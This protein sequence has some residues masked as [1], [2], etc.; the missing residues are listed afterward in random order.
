MVL[1]YFVGFGNGRVSI[2][3]IYCGFFFFLLFSLHLLHPL[4]NFLAINRF[5]AGGAVFPEPD[6]VFAD[7]L[8]WKIS[9]RNQVAGARACPTFLTPRN[10]AK[11]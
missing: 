2:T 5:E 10:G 8:S 3:C 4:R 6:D 1:F 9:I 7:Q 11:C